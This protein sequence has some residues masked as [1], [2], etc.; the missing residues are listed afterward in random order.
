MPHS[1]PLWR[2]ACVSGKLACWAWKRRADSFGTR[3]CRTIYSL[4]VV[5]GPTKEEEEGWVVATQLPHELSSTPGVGATFTCLTSFDQDMCSPQWH[6]SG[7]RGLVDDDRPPGANRCSSNRSHHHSLLGAGCRPH[8]RYSRSARKG[9]S[10]TVP[11]R[12]GDGEWT[13]SMWRPTNITL[14]GRRCASHEPAA[15]SGRRV[16][17]ALRRALDC[18][19]LLR[20]A[21]GCYSTAAGSAP[22]WRMAYIRTT[23]V[24][25]VGMARQPDECP[26]RCGRATVGRLAY[27]LATRVDVEPGDTIYV[28]TVRTYVAARHTTSPQP[29][30]GA[31]RSPTHATHATLRLQSGP[32]WNS[33][34][35]G[36]APRKLPTSE[37]RAPLGTKYVRTYEQRLPSQGVDLWQPRQ[38]RYEGGEW[39]F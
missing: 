2:S 26:G 21:R 1:T 32:A 8:P 37:P 24:E 25:D 23:Y 14:I 19:A 36:L 20:I 15:S 38:K 5:H 10:C 6:V 9:S 27:V 33:G 39:N 29:P 30:W 35:I 4:C 18:C 34:E 31:G 13:R 11:K 28:R 7:G 16:F 12:N 22:A 17:S 3:T